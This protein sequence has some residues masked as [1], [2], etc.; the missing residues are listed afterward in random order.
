V[1]RAVRAIEEGKEGLWVG[2]VEGGSGGS[3][4]LVQARRE[5]AVRAKEEDKVCAVGGGDRCDGRGVGLAQ[6]KGREAEEDVRA[7]SPGFK[8]WRCNADSRDIARERRDAGSRGGGVG[9]GGAAKADEAVEDEEADCDPGVDSTPGQRSSNIIPSV[10]WGDVPG[11]YGVG[12]WDM[13]K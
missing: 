7:W 6:P 3:G 11:T 4:G 8:T 1:G 9:E 5:S 10:D 13:V 12:H 2:G